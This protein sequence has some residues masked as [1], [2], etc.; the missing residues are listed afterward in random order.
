MLHGSRKEGEA[1]MKIWEITLRG[2]TGMNYAVVAKDID[3]ALKKAK[4]KQKIAERD[5]FD[6]SVIGISMTEYD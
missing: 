1:R 5:G 6:H 4:A 2:L 3:E